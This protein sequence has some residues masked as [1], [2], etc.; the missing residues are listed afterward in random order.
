MSVFL[1][2]SRLTLRAFTDADVDHV[3]ELHNDPEVMHYING[4]SP[5]S[6]ETFLREV[7]AR[8]VHD[9]PCV[10]GRAFWIAQERDTGSF[11]GWF[12]FRPTADDSC[13]TVEL[14]YRLNRAAWGRGLATEG[15]RALIRKGFTEL[16]VL[17]VTAYTMTVNVRS[18]RVME[19]AGLRHVRT[20]FEE[21]PHKIDGSEHGDVEYWLTRDAW[22]RQNTPTAPGTRRPF[23]GL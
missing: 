4:G 10:G 9:R 16:G 23:T 13:E 11:L 20:F 21:W 14:G 17:R 7:L 18:R 19:K 15:A 3:L 8:F 12:E 22:Q 1:E 2:T 5:T 6:R